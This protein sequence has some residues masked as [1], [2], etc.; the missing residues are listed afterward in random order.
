[1]IF[2]R[3]G[4][5]DKVKKKKKKKKSRGGNKGALRQER[6]LLLYKLGREALTEQ[7]DL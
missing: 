6:G 4:P 7:T 5:K 1:M 2:I 3:D